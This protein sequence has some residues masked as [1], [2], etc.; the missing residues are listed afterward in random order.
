MENGQRHCMVRVGSMQQL[1]TVSLI[2]LR[3]VDGSLVF[4]PETFTEEID[5]LISV[6]KNQPESW[7]VGRLLGG[8][9]DDDYLLAKVE[10]YLPG[11]IVQRFLVLDGPRAAFRRIRRRGHLGPP[12]KRLSFRRASIPM[13]TI[14]LR[15]SSTANILITIQEIPRFRSLFLI[16]AKEIMMFLDVTNDR[17]AVLIAEG[18]KRNVT[19]D[20]IVTGVM[21]GVDCF[22]RAADMQVSW[23][24][25]K[26]LCASVA[27]EDLKHPVELRLADLYIELHLMVFS[28][29]DVYDQ[30]QLRRT[31][32]CFQNLLTLPVVRQ[33]TILP[34]SIIIVQVL[35]KRASSSRKFLLA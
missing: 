22:V 14:R 9:R 34:Q 26:T 6:Q 19:N 7:Q 5:V 3:L 29:L 21:R 24:L 1:K 33:C 20:D 35:S 31:C 12:I 17:V 16:H 13:A 30:H 11:D 2:H 32:H 4:H 8:V 23:A 10:V 25:D 27:Q 18:N 28:Y 15:C